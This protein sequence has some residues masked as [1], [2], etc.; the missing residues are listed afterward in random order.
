MYQYFRCGGSYSKSTTRYTNCELFSKPAL[1]GG[2]LNLTSS[3]TVSGYTM[4]G[5]SG[6]SFI[7]ISSSGTSAGTVSDDSEHNLTIPSFTFN[8]VA[9]TTA[10]VGNNGVLV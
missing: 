3:A 9:Y 7:D 10:R 5:N 2:T 4:N 6:V 1:P 8:G